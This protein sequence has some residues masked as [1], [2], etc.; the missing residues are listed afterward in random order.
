MTRAANHFY[1][2]VP[3]LSLSL[4]TCLSRSLS[5]ALSL[6]LLLSDNDDEVVTTAFAVSRLDSLGRRRLLL[7]GAA[8]MI[9]AAS[10][11]TIAFASG[12]EIDTSARAA[13]DGDG[14]VDDAAEAAAAE[15]AHLRPVA[16]SDFS[17][18]LVV[19]GCGAYIM[20][21]QFSFGPVLWPLFGEFENFGFLSPSLS[22]SL[23]LPL[24]FSRLSRDGW[25]R[26]TMG[27]PA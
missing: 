21:Y 11:L 22:L 19:L 3:Y 24:S 14:D 25:R 2:R 12:E 5:P 23:S 15:D 10:L 1:G 7:I 16:M 13:G 17:R 9:G 26:S 4:S 18:A 6:S 20:A 27:P 8:T